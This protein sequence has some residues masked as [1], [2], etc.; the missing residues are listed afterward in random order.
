MALCRSLHPDVL[1]VDHRMPPGDTGVQVA[2]RLGAELPG[3]RVIVYTN[4]GDRR[5]GDAARTSGA[6]MILKGNLAALRRA[7]LAP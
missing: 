4:H 6:R 3:L 1:V 2:A 7:V 5:L